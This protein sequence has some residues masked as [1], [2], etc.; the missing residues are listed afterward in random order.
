MT[1]ETR[2]IQN[3]TMEEAYFNQFILL[4]N[5]LVSAA[6][7]FAGEGNLSLVL[8]P[9]MSKDMDEQLNLAHNVVDVVDRANRKICVTLLQYNVDKP[10][11]SYA[12]VRLFAKRNEDENFQQTVYVNLKNSSFYLI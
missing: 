7:N 4:R 6:V 2:L 1:K 9:T 5:Q 8:I 12:H 10:E 3:L 11:N